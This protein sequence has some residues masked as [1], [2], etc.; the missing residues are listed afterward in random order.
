MNTYLK[1]IK[2]LLYIFIPILLFTIFLSIFYYFNI[3]NDSLLNIF[4]LLTTSLS[5]LIGGL[6]IG[7]KVNKKGYIE[8]L[9]EGLIVV[10]LLFL[11]SYLG[12]NKGINI[13]RF[14]YYIILIIS[15]ILGSMIGI[16]KKDG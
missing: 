12:F 5:M 11:I 10:I 6:Y 9:K 13:N 1:Y 2:A 16:N 15:S 4:K 3:I 7:K 8:G 14:I